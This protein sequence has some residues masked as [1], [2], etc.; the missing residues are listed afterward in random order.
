[1]QFFRLEKTNRNK[2]RTPVYVDV[3]SCF[4]RLLL[5]LILLLL[6]LLLACAAAASAAAAA[7][8]AADATALSLVGPAP[9]SFFPSTS[10]AKAI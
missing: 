5:L 8:V 4:R 10:L 9:C 1:M 3:R 7:A 6:L 2:S